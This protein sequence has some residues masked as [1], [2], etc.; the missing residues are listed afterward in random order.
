M[1]WSARSSSSPW[2][3][4]QGGGLVAEDASR[5]R[6]RRPRATGRAPGRRA[7]TPWPPPR[8]CRRRASCSAD[9]ER[10]GDLL[11]VGLA[12]GVEEVLGQ[13][14]LGLL[15]LLHRLAHPLEELVELLL[16]L[17]EPLAD[18]LALVG[19]AERLP[20]GVWF[21]ASSCSVSLLLVLVELPGL[22][23]HLGHLLGEPVRGLLAEL[24]AEVVQ[25]P[26]GAGPF[27]DGLR[28]AALL[29]RLGGLA[30]VLAALLDLLAGLG[31]AVAVL[32]ALHPL[33]E[34]VGVAEDLL[35]LVPEPL[36]LPLDLLAG[37]L[38][39]WPPRGPIAAP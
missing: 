23:A 30:D 6:A 34:L 10:V 9:L 31:H 38:R 1:T 36:E 19:V 28:E 11:L 25:L 33:P 3:R 4:A 13:Q 21:Q 39:P 16:L 20:L 26:A 35:L 22:V 15:G 2:A 27:G 24:L 5:P 18:L 12:D 37:L 14:R 8:R 17:L 29:E 7:G 32:L